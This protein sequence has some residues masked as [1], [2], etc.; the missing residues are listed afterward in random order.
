MYENYYGFNQKPFQKTPDPSFF[1]RSDAHQEALDRL[2]FAVEESDLMVIV[3]EVGT[4]KTLLTRALLEELDDEA[5][6]VAMLLNPRLTPT[7]L[8]RTLALEWGIAE[9]KRYKADLWAQLSDRL[10]ECHQAGI[11]PVAIIEEAQ[12]INRADVFDELRL[13][14][15]FQLDDSNLFSLILVGQPEL[16][17]YLNR[18]RLRA[19]RQRIGIQYDLKPLSR[20]EAEQ[21]IQYRLRIAGRV[22]SLFSEDAITTLYEH[23]QGLPRSLNNLANMALLA[24]FTRQAQTIDRSLVESIVYDVEGRWRDE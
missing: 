6:L 11:L 18:K 21:Y 22:G 14:T 23:A 5:H 2:L 3:G 16:K 7:Q 19:F 13:L 12:L 9:P 24:G 20:N 10:W 8:L 4:G 17:K 1:Y 15:N